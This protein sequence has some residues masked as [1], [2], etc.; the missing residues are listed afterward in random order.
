MGKVKFG[1][2]PSDVRAKVGNVVYF[3]NRGGAC[4]RTRVDPR[5]TLTP[6]RQA[7]HTAWQTAIAGWF[8]SITD[9]KIKA[10]EGYAQLL[11]RTDQFG[12]PKSYDPLRA[13]LAVNVRRRLLNLPFLATPPA[14]T[15]VQGL[16]SAAVTVSGTP[17]YPVTVTFS[18]SPLPAGH[19]IWIFATTS[20]GIGTRQYKPFLRWIGASPAQQSSPFNA[21]TLYN[22]RFP[23][24]FS[25]D[26]IGFRIHVMNEA[27]G[28]IDPGIDVRALVS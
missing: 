15:F 18:P 6:A 23:P 24:P 10:W 12:Q 2:L 27:N 22:N 19:R 9:A 11:R 3:R 17:P 21:T 26:A 20:M 25:G 14:N 13:F 16:T 8:S 1:I 7:I 5:Q 4:V 28:L